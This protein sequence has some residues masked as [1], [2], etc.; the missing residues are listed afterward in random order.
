MMFYWVQ[1]RYVSFLLCHTMWKVSVFGVFLVRIFPHS[2][3]I[4]RDTPN[5]SVFSSN[6]RKYGPQKLRIQ[7][8]FTQCSREPFFYIGSLISLKISLIFFPFRYY[9][10]YFSYTSLCENKYGDS[11]STC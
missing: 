11:K 4:Q 10:V 6:T 3:R 9:K 7:T 5:P 1:M 2:D 8:L